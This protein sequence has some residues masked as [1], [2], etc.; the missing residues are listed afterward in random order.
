MKM[1]LSYL[2]RNLASFKHDEFKYEI[3][4]YLPIFCSFRCKSKGAKED[5]TSVF[6][7]PTIKSKRGLKKATVSSTAELEED[8]L[9]IRKRKLLLEC[10]KLSLEIKILKKDFEA[11]D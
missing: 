1:F 8:I 9:R 10:S 2:N 3:F 6:Q 11:M 4:M 7:K 5:K